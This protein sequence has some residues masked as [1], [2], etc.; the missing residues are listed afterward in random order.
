MKKIIFK[1][2]NFLL[3]NNKI[4]IFKIIQ[5]ISNIIKKNLD[6]NLLVVIGNNKWNYKITITKL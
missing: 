2:N 3:K 5:R 6:F 4:K 1:K